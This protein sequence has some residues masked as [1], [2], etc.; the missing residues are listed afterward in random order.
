[1]FKL[2]SQVLSKGQALPFTPRVQQTLLK[3]DKVKSWSDTSF[4]KGSLAAALR[5][6]GGACRAVEEVLAGRARNAIAVTRPPGYRPYRLWC[7]ICTY[8]KSKAHNSYA[9][10]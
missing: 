9:T 2:H 1:M 6:A 5:A 7:Y 10:L 4:S 8:E 3:D